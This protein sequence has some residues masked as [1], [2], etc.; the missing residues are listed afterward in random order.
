[1]LEQ[2]KRA[3]QKGVGITEEDFDKHITYPH[4]RKIIEKREMLLQY[5][6]VAEVTQSKYCSAG[7]KPGMKLVFQMMPAQL[8]PAESNCPVCLRAIGPI[9]P[10]AAG[11]W[12][13]LYE[14]L[15]PN[16]GMW[17]ISEC[18]DPGLDK[19]GLG[20]VVFKVYAQKI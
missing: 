13:R 20:H 10:L 3:M 11:F 12:D 18:M 1:M 9:A 2:A 6:I 19:G 15:D 17:Y 5:R 16:S 8:I 14:G 4:N 7:L